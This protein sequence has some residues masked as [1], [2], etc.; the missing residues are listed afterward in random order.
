MSAFNQRVINKDSI[1]RRQAEFYSACPRALVRVKDS[2]IY[3]SPRRKNVT[4]ECLNP[5]AGSS[6]GAEAFL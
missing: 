1:S 2:L 5:G 6:F 4:P 3:W